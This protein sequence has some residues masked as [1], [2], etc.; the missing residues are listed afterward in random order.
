MRAR[1][2]GMS[3]SQPDLAEVGTIPKAVEGERQSGVKALVLDYVMVFRMISPS[4][5]GEPLSKMQCGRLLPV[6]TGVQFFWV[7]IFFIIELS[8]GAGGTS[9][10]A[11]ARTVMLFFVY[12]LVLI[13]I[14]FLISRAA[15]AG[16]LQKAGLVQSACSCW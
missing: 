11:G 3:N 1:R 4:F 9:G 10:V 6:T 14:S 2:G 8:G 7:V 15:V 16:R 13:P 12:L 5:S